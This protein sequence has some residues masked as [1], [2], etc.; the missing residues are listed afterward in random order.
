[1]AQKCF[2]FP[3]LLP[4]ANNY[5]ILGKLW[6]EKIIFGLFAQNRAFRKSVAHWSHMKGVAHWSHSCP[7]L[8]F[9]IGLT[10]FMS[11]VVI[12][13]YFS[14]LLTV[15]NFSLKCAN[16]KKEKILFRERCF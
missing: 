1:L 8:V 3:S 12:A 14:L 5:C 7:L 4:I 11:I 10:R 13:G 15:Y 16:V 6:N 2:P 9:P